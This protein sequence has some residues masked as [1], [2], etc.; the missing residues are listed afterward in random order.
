MNDLDVGAECAFNM[1][2]A[3]TKLRGVVDRPDICAD[4][5]RAMDRLE[6]CDNRKL[7]KYRKEKCKV[8]HVVRNNPVT[9]TDWLGA[10]WPECRLAKIL[11]LGVWWTPV[12]MQ[13][14]NIILQQGRVRVF[15]AAW[16]G[17]WLTDQCRWSS[18][19]IQHWW[20]HTQSAGS[21][22]QL[23]STRESYCTT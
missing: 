8:L 18:P 15:W 22:S 5:Q 4:I 3:D 21:S 14:S 6:K 13:A 17:V 19:S 20:G 12:W 7:L 9:N 11:D 16:R 10:D 23:S 2:A 1:L